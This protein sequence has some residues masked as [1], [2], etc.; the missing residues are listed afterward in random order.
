M[1]NKSL[2]VQRNELIKGIYKNFNTVDIKMFK[3]IVSKVYSRDLMFNDFYVL[4]NR[5]IKEK[6]GVNDNNISVIIRN[7]LEK[8]QSLLIRIYDDESGF[9]NISCFESVEYKRNEGKYVIVFSNS[10]V[11]YLL[12]IKE[13]FTDYYLE[14]ILNL[15][16]CEIKLYENL[17]MLSFS[18]VE[19]K[20]DSLIELM[21]L[22][23]SYKEFYNFKKLF[24]ESVKN[25]NEN[26]DIKIIDYFYIKDSRKYNKVK[27]FIERKK[28]K[29]LSDIEKLMLFR[30]ERIMYSNKEFRI[31]DID[32]L[33]EENIVKVVIFNSVE[34]LKGTMSFK[35]GIEDC[36]KRLNE[37]KID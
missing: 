9:K 21:E 1:S 35:D 34:E 19:Y 2:V 25:I 31:M 8:I 27:F 28:K 4:N 18:E 6:L 24:E 36:L 17:K 20:I 23:S 16:K 32:Y 12:D 3:L 33:K 37:M 13:K 10:M 26:S 7:S 11:K 30:D 29:D 22:K 5:E 14:N 15:K